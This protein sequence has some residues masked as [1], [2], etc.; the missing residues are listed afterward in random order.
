MAASHLAATESFALESL[1]E[2]LGEVVEEEVM[3]VV[4]K[5]LSTIVSEALGGSRGGSQATSRVE[6]QWA[7]PRSDL[8]RTEK[9]QAS[10]PWANNGTPWR[11]TVSCEDPQSKPEPLLPAKVPAPTDWPAPMHHRGQAGDPFAPFNAYVQDQYA[12]SVTAAQPRE[13]QPA[14][15][16]PQ[17]AHA[18]R[19]AP[20][21]GAS[22]TVRRR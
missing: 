5:A 22:S 8:A 9:P 21:R 16:R 2:I 14:Q 18:R 15:R 6:S 1:Q 20:S 10:G 11:V 13:K 3:T 12:Q 19:P 4:S 7:A 17:S